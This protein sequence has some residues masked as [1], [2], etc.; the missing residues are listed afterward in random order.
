MNEIVTTAEERR[1]T[2][3]ISESTIASARTA[4]IT[5]LIKPSIRKLAAVYGMSKTVL[6]KYMVE[7]DWESQRHKY[8]QSI[9]TSAQNKLM[10]QN[11][12]V[13][14]AQL[15]DV[16]TILS[17]ATGRMKLL[18]SSGE[19]NPSIKDLDMLIRLDAFISGEPD[20][21]T[22][23]T[24]KLDKPLSEYT[25][26]EL[27]AIRNRVLEGE[28]ELIEND[29]ENEEEV[30]GAEMDLANEENSLEEAANGQ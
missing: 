5:S 2:Q 11:K 30:D 16:R 1:A 27:V 14:A 8:Q 21:R 18:M 4:F 12:R 10:L 6:H 13:R 25:K 9:T 20:S 7:Q 23:K 24:I 29:E 26:D 17:L 15:S 22:E 3:E 28:F 19:Y